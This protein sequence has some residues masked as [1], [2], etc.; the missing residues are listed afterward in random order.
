MHVLF[1]MFSYFMWAEC[2]KSKRKSKILDWHQNSYRMEIFGDTPEFPHLEGLSSRFLFWLWAKKNWQGYKPPLIYPKKQV[3]PF[4]PAFKCISRR[5][6]LLFFY[7]IEWFV[8]TKIHNCCRFAIRWG[9]SFHS[10]KWAN[11][12]NTDERLNSGDFL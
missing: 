1:G 8:H 9:K 2:D 3:L 5:H 7:S 6:F 12:K 10:L 11:K 4:S